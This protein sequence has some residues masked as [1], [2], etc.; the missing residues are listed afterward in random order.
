MNEF[1]KK[2][3]KGN[4]QALG[5]VIVLIVLIIGVFLNKMFA[6]II[7]SAGLAV[8][9][10][11]G[12]AHSLATMIYKWRIMGVTEEG[13]EHLFES[14]WRYYILED[15]EDRIEELERFEEDN[16]EYTYLKKVAEV[17]RPRI[18]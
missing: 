3:L 16:L 17:K 8:C 11:M 7:T 18:L 13:E 4:L 9:L 1:Q 15:L 14:C 2:K 12:L 6:L 5:L 10:A